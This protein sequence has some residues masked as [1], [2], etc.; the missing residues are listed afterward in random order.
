VTKTTT[1]FRRPL[2]YHEVPLPPEGGFDHSYL[3]AER[4]IE[5]QRIH[6]AKIRRIKEERLDLYAR[7]QE[8]EG[9]RQVVY[10]KC[11]RDPEWFIDMFV[12]TYDDREGDI[13]PMVLF[14]FQ[15]DKLVRPYNE[16]CRVVA[17]RRYTGM[18]AKSRAL[19][20]SWVSMALRLCSFLFQ[21][22]WSCLI[23]G[24][25]RDD[26]D[27]GGQAATTQSLFGKLR[28]M[29][30]HLPEW[31]QVDLLGPRWASKDE[32]NKRMSIKNPLKPLNIIDGK[33]LGGMFGRGRRYSE[34]FG[35]EVAWADE[36]EDADTALK[37]T[38]NRF[39]G[40][41]TPKGMVGFFPQMMFGDL[42]IH[43]YWCWW[44][45][46]PFLT[47]D[48]YNEQRQEMTDAQIAQELDISFEKS[49]GGTVIQN[50]S[51]SD[52]FKPAPWDP[53]LPTQVWIDPGWAD[54]MGAI[55]VQWD[56]HREEGRIVDMVCTRKRRIDWIVPF[57]TGFIPDVDSKGLPWPHHYNEEELALIKTAD[58]R[59]YQSEAFELLG[60]YGGGAK[61]AATGTSCWDE[62][63]AYGLFVEG[64]KMPKNETALEH[65]NLVLRHVVCDDAIMH[66][67]NGPKDE[68][69][70]ML[71]VFSQWRYPARRPGAVR[72]STVPVH[73]RFC[74]VGD[75]IK[76]WCWDMD[77]PQ[78][79]AMDTRLRKTVLA[80]P[81][82]QTRT[83]YR[84]PF[85]S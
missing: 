77:V 53:H 6:L 39:F 46:H 69:P 54:N 75:C 59:L 2:E 24:E 14:P 49:L 71:E 20:W 56:K 9:F 17:P 29:I 5:L 34:V 35:D 7:C 4:K 25:Q 3:E 84:N 28:F 36:M 55:W 67:R 70:T 26:V 16:M 23:G 50:I 10:E 80:D 44:A 65:M 48:W 64:V 11:R 79:R 13:K 8:D 83:P 30:A 73:D 63:E 47:L 37:Q 72:A 76:M 22:N 58:E 12:W 27:D 40:G 52:F 66:Q 41:S 15:V 85:R 33:Q 43:R 68:S 31:M 51:P 61:S 62:L 78:P 45:E 74:H 32:F 38:T 81:R 18:I 42:R 82:K 60:D 21:E 1:N 19:G 57:I